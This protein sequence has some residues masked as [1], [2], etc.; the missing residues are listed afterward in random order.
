M[1][2]LL[3]VCVLMTSFLFF[4]GPRSDSEIDFVSQ[5]KGRPDSRPTKHQKEERVRRGGVDTQRARQARK[6]GL[7]CMLRGWRTNAAKRNVT[8]TKPA[9]TFN[10]SALFGV[11]LWCLFFCVAERFFLS[12]PKFLLQHFFFT[13]TEKTSAKP[14]LH[15]ADNSS[16]RCWLGWGSFFRVCGGKRFAFAKIF[17]WKIS[18]FFSR[19]TQKRRRRTCKT[20]SG[21]GKRVHEMKF[22]ARTKMRLLLCRRR[23]RSKNTLSR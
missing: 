23:G 4:D 8:H 15:D 5:T 1:P 17:F 22:R 14:F 3:L 10:V 11:R 20:R 7:C 6:F 19:H 13:P 16:V 18:V 21:H 9:D 2:V 12:F